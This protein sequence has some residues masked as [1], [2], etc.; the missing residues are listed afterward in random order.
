MADLP[1]MLTDIPLVVA[2]LKARHAAGHGKGQRRAICAAL[3]K[4]NYFFASD[5]DK[6]GLTGAVL[7]EAR[8]RLLLLHNA[9][10]RSY[11]RELKLAHSRE[12]QE[13]NGTWT[14]FRGKESALHYRRTRMCHTH[15]SIDSSMCR[16][17]DSSIH[18]SILS[19][20]SYDD[21]FIYP[22]HLLY[23][24]TYFSFS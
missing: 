3:L 21:T 14:E 16:L 13:S 20:Y 18:L 10:H 17:I 15:L 9:L 6:Y 24:T 1:K 19:I 7:E 12:T 5:P 11:E 4:I 22:L 8:G 2:H 23:L